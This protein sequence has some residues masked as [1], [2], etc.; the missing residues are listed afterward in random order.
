MKELAVA[1]FVLIYMLNSYVWAQLVLVLE[2]SLSSKIL[3]KLELEFW[4]RF[5]LEPIE[6]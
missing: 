5:K 4:A 3:I 6:F 2:L 1:R